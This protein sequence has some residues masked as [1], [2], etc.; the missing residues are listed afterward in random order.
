MPVVNGPGKRYSAESSGRK[1]PG[2]QAGQ[3]RGHRHQ[4]GSRRRQGAGVPPPRV[5]S[6][7]RGR[8]DS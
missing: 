7:G 1:H 5:L 6:G 3:A 8:W 4:P 2:G